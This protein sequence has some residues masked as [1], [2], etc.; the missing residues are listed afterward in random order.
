MSKKRI[1]I[2]LPY[3][4]NI[5][6]DTAGAV[7]IYVKDTSK[8]SKYKNDITIISSENFDKMKLFRNKNYIISFCKKYKNTKIDIIEIH[9]R[10]EYLFYLK[11]YFPTAKINLF[12]HNDPLT[13]RGSENPREREYILSN[14]DKIIFLSNWIQQMFFYKL[15]NINLDSVITLPVGVI[16]ENNIRL[17]KKKKKYFVCW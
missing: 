1:F 8:Y 14:T 7:S 16:K 10:P 17:N 15:K 4:E 3:K 11:K 13:L 9:N 5:N 2:I 6:L 12:F